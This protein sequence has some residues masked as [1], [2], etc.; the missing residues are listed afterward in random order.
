MS[1]CRFLLN[2]HRRGRLDIDDATAAVIGRGDVLEFHRSIPGYCATPL[3][4]LPALARRL[5]VG[6]ILVK[7]ESKRFH[8]SAFKVLGASYA[9]SCYYRAAWQGKYAEPFAFA[10]LFNGR[11]RDKLGPVTFCTATDGNHGRAVAWMASLTG[12]RSV[13]YMPGNSVRSRIANIEREG[14]T[15][16]VVDGTYDDAVSGVA[17]DAA[18]NGWQIISDTA[19]PGYTTI[20]LHV[21]AGYSTLF[22]EIDDGLAEFDLTGIDVVFIQSGVGSL[23]AAAVWHYRRG[24]TAS[25]RTALVNIEPHEAD[26][27]MASARTSDGVMRSTTGSQKTIMAGLNCGTPSLVA[28]PIIKQ[29]MDLFIS[30]PDEW[31]EQAVGTYYHPADAD[32]QIIS[33]ESG[34]AGMAGL[35]ALCSSDSLAPARKELDLHKLSRVLLINTEGATDPDNF[36]KI[37][38]A[39]T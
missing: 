28:W 37:I 16:V 27:L 10:D 1:V 4:S 11:V 24:Q 32:P 6:Q 33:G 38:G 20:P 30:L 21:I 26:C 18:E 35:L 36:A 9:M 22:R 3:V 25:R 23:A 15:V 14:A 2:P 19:Y 39:A 31:C 8:L 5:G 17:R 29:G 7:D 34:A 13:I 12:N